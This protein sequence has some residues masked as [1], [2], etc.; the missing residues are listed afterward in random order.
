MRQTTLCILKERHGLMV[1]PR[2]R[3]CER[4]N[5][6]VE[7]EHLWRNRIITH[8]LSILAMVALI[9]FDVSV[10]RASLLGDRIAMLIQ[11]TVNVGLGPSPIGPFAE[12]VMVEDP[13][14]EVDNVD[15]FSGV[16]FLTVDVDPVSETIVVDLSHTFPVAVNVIDV[17]G[18][19]SDLDWLDATG[20][21]IAASISDAFISSNPF[22]LPLD[23]THT[24]DS[25]TVTNS[26]TFQI[27]AS[28]S[29]EFDITY[30]T[31]HIPEPPTLALA[32]LVLLSF[33]A[34]GRRRCA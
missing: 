20:A 15:I 6:C 4:V 25:I 3:T 14:V 27:A 17:I 32:A 22:G 33:L 9:V 23:V 7:H 21:P 34:H 30:A 16:A 18:I 28:S 24:A 11:G 8:I 19:F 26:S 5:G 29:A 1:G 2:S 31:E 12:N 10:A 13:D